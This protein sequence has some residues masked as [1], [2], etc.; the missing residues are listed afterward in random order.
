M[1]T[2]AETGLVVGGWLPADVMLHE[3][4]VPFA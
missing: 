1:T 2:V 3:K 4:I